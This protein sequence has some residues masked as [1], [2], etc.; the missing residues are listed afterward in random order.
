MYCNICL[1]R[2][3]LACFENEARVTFE[4]GIVNFKAFDWLGRSGLAQ[5][6]RVSLKT[7]CLSGIETS[8]TLLHNHIMAS[9]TLINESQSSLQPNDSASVISYDY[10]NDTTPLEGAS[11][12]RTS[13][14]RRRLNRQRDKAWDY[15]RTPIKGVE[16]HSEKDGR[17][18][19]RIWYC[20]Y[21][22]CERYSCLSTGAARGHMKSI[23][24]VNIDTNTPSIVEQKKQQ[25]LKKQF[26]DHEQK[27]QDMERNNGLE[28]LRKAA[29]PAVVKQTVLRLIVHHDLPFNAAQWPEL[30]ALIYA[31]PYSLG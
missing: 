13:H 15:C 4:K 11:E 10:D 25:N 18:V 29:V 6:E 19:R 3:K 1:I 14:K 16:P 17:R 22:C 5:P 23:H 26:K 27:E 8:I 31:L 7:L 28:A 2:C 12:A 9:A 21:P 30:H 24:S 20:K